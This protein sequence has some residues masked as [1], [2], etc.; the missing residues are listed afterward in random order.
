[1]RGKESGNRGKKRRV[2]SDPMGL[3]ANSG[4]SL[5]FVYFETSL[6]FSSVCSDVLIDLYCSVITSEAHFF[7]DRVV[8]W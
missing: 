7:L 1:M 2:R 3:T 6:K 4:T 8:L 5:D